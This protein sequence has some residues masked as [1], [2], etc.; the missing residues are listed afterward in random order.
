M[1]EL[2]LAVQQMGGQDGTGIVAGSIGAIPRIRKVAA[3]ARIRNIS[4]AREIATCIS[5]T[6]F[7]VCMRRGLEGGPTLPDGSKRLAN[8]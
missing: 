2:P 8:D 1:V 7:R 3:T 5:V 6:S 4:R